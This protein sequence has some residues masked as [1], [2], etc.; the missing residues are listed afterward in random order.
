MKYTI[1]LIVALFT[2][3]SAQAQQLD[4]GDRTSATITGNGVNSEVL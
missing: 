2:S 1:T 4:F 3:L